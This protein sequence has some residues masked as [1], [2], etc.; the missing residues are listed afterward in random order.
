MNGG[1]V[2]DWAGAANAGL[3]TVLPYQSS[4]RGPVVPTEYV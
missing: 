2:R 1:V 4:R 3:A